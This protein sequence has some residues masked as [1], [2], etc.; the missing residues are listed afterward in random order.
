MRDGKEAVQLAQ[1]AVA[2]SGGQEPMFLATLAAAYAE[3][4]QFPDAV[5][6]A[7]AAITLAVCQ[8]RTSLADALRDKLGSYRVGSTGEDAR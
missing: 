2:L 5:E 8:N 4:G 7:Q 6:T 1:R 3:S